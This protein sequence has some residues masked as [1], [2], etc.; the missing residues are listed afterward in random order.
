MRSRSRKKRIGMN[1]PLDP[2]RMSIYAKSG[3][4]RKEVVEEGR[5]ACDNLVLNVFEKR[6]KYTRFFI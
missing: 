6:V 3:L 1:D 2:K 4:G 5:V